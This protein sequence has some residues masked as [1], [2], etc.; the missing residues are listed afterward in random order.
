MKTRNIVIDNI[1]IPEQSLY[2]DIE[3]TGLSSRRSRIYLIGALYADASKAVLTQWFAESLS[4]EKEM[5][6]AFNDL[7]SHHRCLISYNG[8]AFDIP[9]LRGAMKQYSIRECISGM[10]SLDIYARIRR[11]RGLFP[12]D[13]MTLRSMEHFLGIDRDDTFSGRDLISVYDEYLGSH[14]EQLL[15]FLLLHNEEDV[16]SLPALVKLINY[17]R[18]LGGAYGDGIL[19]VTQTGSVPETSGDP[20]H[21][22]FSARLAYPV[23]KPVS[24]AD[25]GFS[26]T[27]QDDEISVQVDALTGELRHFF[28]DYKNYYY[29]PSEDTA[30]HKSVG[31][32]TDKASRVKASAPT[33][34]VRKRGVFIPVGSEIANDER[35]SAV[36]VF[37][38]EYKDKCPYILLDTPALRD[39]AFIRCCIGYAL[40]ELGLVRHSFRAPEE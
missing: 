38:R 24:C 4:D 15:G 27:L 36:P 5:L 32:F 2:F 20:R 9:F 14:D 39:P 21:V 30:M 12:T 22:S 19:T 33:A 40:S 31:I 17:E 28:S 23:P 10:E 6:T 1:T 13:D 26:L 18:S 29:I 3:T 34:F 16:R 35:W 37:H 8:E 11:L 25:H 7:C